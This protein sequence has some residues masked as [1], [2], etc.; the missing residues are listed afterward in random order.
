MTTFASA[1]VGGA[2]VNWTRADTGVSSR[3]TSVVSI[4][5]TTDSFNRV[6]GVSERGEYVGWTVDLNEVISPKL[7]GVVHSVD[8]QIS[9]A[10]IVG[11]ATFGED[12]DCGL[13]FTSGKDIVLA[14]TD[15][16]NQALVELRT[17]IESTA[18][19]DAAGIDI[20][21]DGSDEIVVL[22]SGLQGWIIWEY[23]DDQGDI[24][25]SSSWR[26]TVCGERSGYWLEVEPGDI[27]GSG[28]PELI[29]LSRNMSLI[30]HVPRNFM[31]DAQAKIG[32]GIQIVESLGLV[33][34]RID[35]GLRVADL[36]GDGVSEVIAATT[37]PAAV[38]YWT[39]DRTKRVGE[40]KRELV[41]QAEVLDIVPIQSSTGAV[42]VVSTWDGIECWA[43]G[44]GGPDCRGSWSYPKDGRPSG[45]RY[46]QSQLAILSTGD[47]DKVVFVVP[48]LRNEL[49][50]WFSDPISIA[51]GGSEDDSE[52]K[53]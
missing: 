16:T 9:N 13:I 14:Y 4:H 43:A 27:V 34:E 47:R 18:V 38:Y 41:V 19:L 10:S 24:T 23:A 53:R 6:A 1:L 8:E 3:I 40:W 17:D 22:Y 50:I 31:R 52:V 39:L 11:R 7:S 32:D 37:N 30:A 21:G 12:G 5:H 49:F 15:G 42:V 29:L 36:T 46:S 28:N 45:N 33:G 48:T 26:Y 25:S 2:D 51:S 20:D 35:K 44:L